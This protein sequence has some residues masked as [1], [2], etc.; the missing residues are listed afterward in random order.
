MCCLVHA[1]IY[2]VCHA[3]PEGS[4]VTAIAITESGIYEKKSHRC[5]LKTYMFMHAI[6]ISKAYIQ[7]SSLILDNT[8]LMVINKLSCNTILP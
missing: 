2:T 7:T 6:C 3:I 8:K 4:M 5:N 1:L